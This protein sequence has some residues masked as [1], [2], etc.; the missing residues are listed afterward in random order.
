M[1]LENVSRMCTILQNKG[2]EAFSCKTIFPKTN[3]SWLVVE[4]NEIIPECRTCSNN[5]GN[6]D[7]YVL[8]HEYV[9]NG[10]MNNSLNH[11]QDTCVSI[12]EDLFDKLTTRFPFHA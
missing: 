2:Q 8:Y 5:N 9:I 12:L 7:K 11:V 6:D 10:D 4:H 3:A 1:T